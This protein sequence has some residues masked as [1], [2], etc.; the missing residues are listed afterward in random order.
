VTVAS[1]L[2]G[3]RHDSQYEFNEAI[4]PTRLSRGYRLGLLIVTVTMLVLPLI[5]VGLIA[6]VG[7][8]VWWHL[9]TNHWILTGGGGATVWRLVAYLGPVAAGVVLMFFMVKP[10]LARPARR[11]DPLPLR[12][13]DEPL[14]FRF[15]GDICRQV[16]APAPSVIQVDCEV[17]ASAGFASFP[18]GL[19]RPPLVL[20]IGLPLSA[21]LTIRQFGGVLAHEFGHFAQGGGMRLTFTVRSINRWFSRVVHERDEWDEKLDRWSSDGNWM[22]V[23]TLLLARSAVWCSRYILSALMTAGHGISCFMLRQ[24]EYDA[25]SYEVRLVGSSTFLE[26]SARMRELNV[27]AR[28]GYDDLR[29]SWI[30]R[31]LPAN[32]PAFLLRQRA[33]LTADQRA[34]IRRVP[35]EETS[36]FDTH[37]SD[38]DRAA[39]AERAASSGILAGGDGPATA[40]FSSFEALSE[41][42]TRHHYEHDLGVPLNST[43]IVDTEEAL[44]ASRNREDNERAAAMLLGE[45]LTA[46]R[47]MRLTWPG[48][49]VARLELEEVVGSLRAAREAM[50]VDLAALSVKYRR[51]ESLSYSM[52]LAAAA[53]E[54]FECGFTKVIPADFELTDGTLED[55]R[56]TGAR[57]MEQQQEIAPALARFESA[58]DRRLGCSLWL[59]LESIPDPTDRAA[60]EAEITGLVAALD[61]LARG[62]TDLFDLF[63]LAQ[64]CEHLAGNVATCPTPDRARARLDRLLDAST[65]IRRRLRE[66]LEGLAAPS[67][68]ASVN[69]TLT[70]VL[71]LLDVDADRVSGVEI[72]SRAAAVRF[73]LIGRLAAIA[74]N[75]ESNYP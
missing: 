27:D 54:L 30:R 49:D 6:L 15:I 9:A 29:D 34:E 70:S 67:T 37:P 58:V 44:R 46:L 57:A 60:Q 63:R 31:E 8:T 14:L 5:Y 19:R 25:D 4:E 23:L 53:E 66:S 11:A 17:N 69:A 38:A 50:N 56:A 71:G 2:A 36:L 24:M 1:P 32:L 51:F 39:A 61:G 47:P 65:G 3:S 21:G 35:A 64:L 43:T 20:T 41:A 42:A 28:I 68:G 74:L 59:A 48:I 26:T 18:L 62:W 52:S 16:R 22:V 75:G 55:A 7:A 33:R 73:D 10:V 45:G 12:P 40:L 13:D 72:F